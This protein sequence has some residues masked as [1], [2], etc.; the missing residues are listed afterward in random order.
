[1]S[2]WSPWP[3]SPRTEGCRPRP[4]NQ[5]HLWWNRTLQHHRPT[6]YSLRTN[7]GITG[8]LK[9]EVF[10]HHRHRPLPPKPACRG[11]RRV[12][13]FSKREAK[14]SI[15]L[16]KQ[17]SSLKANGS[18]AAGSAV[19]L[20]SLVLSSY[21]VQIGGDSMKKWCSATQVRCKWDDDKR[22]AQ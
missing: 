7:Q 6:L 5:Q 8:D 10:S 3:L 1:V 13:L 16:D 11:S 20:H 9:P 22:Q 2:A 21:R 15:S 4:G 18:L 19:W 14:V 12:C 17:A